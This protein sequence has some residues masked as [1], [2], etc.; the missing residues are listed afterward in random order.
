MLFSPMWVIFQETLALWLTFFTWL[1]QPDW[2]FWRARC[3][4][5]FTAPARFLK[6]RWP[7][8]IIELQELFPRKGSLSYRFFRT[9][10]LLSWNRIKQVVR[11]YGF[12]LHNSTFIACW[13]VRWTWCLLQKPFFT[14]YHGTIIRTGVTC[15]KIPCYMRDSACR[16]FIVKKAEIF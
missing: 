6:C 15:K 1:C 12:C 4:D 5:Y 14:L 8:W 7:L 13:N 2:R 10:L 11:L 16:W 3:L 9:S